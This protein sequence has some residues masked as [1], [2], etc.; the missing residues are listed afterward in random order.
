MAGHPQRKIFTPCEKKPYI[1]TSEMFSFHLEQITRR[2]ARKTEM[3][4]NLIF[5][6][7]TI[8]FTHRGAEKVKKE[9]INFIDMG[10][11]PIQKKHKQIH[12]RILI[13]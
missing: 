4:A 10:M 8:L 2:K 7:I 11:V 5:R 6:Q 9:T 3:R 13:N 12:A 1:C